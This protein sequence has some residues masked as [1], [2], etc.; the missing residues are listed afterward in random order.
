MSRFGTLN[1]CWQ[2]LRQH[3]FPLK[4]GALPKGMIK[5]SKLSNDLTLEHLKS[6]FLYCLTVCLLTQ[7]TDSSCSAAVVKLVVGSKEVKILDSEDVD[8]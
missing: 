4:D 1:T 8:R 2:R 5:V 3:E 6:T 7:F